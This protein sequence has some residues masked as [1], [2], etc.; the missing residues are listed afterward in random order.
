MSRPLGRFG[1]INVLARNAH[2]EHG[3]AE[4]VLQQL[5]LPERC[6]EKPSLHAW[7]ASTMSWD[8]PL[9]A[10]AQ[11]SASLER[12]M[13]RELSS[14]V[15]LPDR[16]DRNGFSNASPTASKTSDSATMTTISDRYAR[17][18]SRS[19]PQDGPADC[20]GHEILVPRSTI[21]DYVGRAPQPA[22]HPSRKRALRLITTNAAAVRPSSW[23]SPQVRRR[24]SSLHRSEAPIAEGQSRRR[25]VRRAHSSARRHR[26]GRRMVG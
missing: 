3:V 1:D 5:P 22:H 18:A 20:G 13:N 17:P 24:P 11:N 21:P 10:S 26:Q 12:D 2:V 8:G 25:H 7:W 4:I 16:H 23:C 14:S 9:C 19:S 6:S 15:G